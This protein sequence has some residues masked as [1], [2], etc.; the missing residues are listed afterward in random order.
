M[1]IFLFKYIMIGTI[2]YLDPLSVPVTATHTPFGPLT[3]QISDSIQVCTRSIMSSL[4]YG[5]KDYK[6]SF[7]ITRLPDIPRIQLHELRN[8]CECMDCWGQPLIVRI[9][10]FQFIIIIQ[11]QS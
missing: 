9:L 2:S 4:K 3:C 1:H 8:V 5:Q 11:F 6:L 10:N 7:T